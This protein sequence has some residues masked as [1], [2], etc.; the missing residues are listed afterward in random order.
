MKTRFVILTERRVLQHLLLEDLHGLVAPA[1]VELF[2]AA[3]QSYDGQ[4]VGADAFVGILQ[5]W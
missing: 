5:Y 3:V 2:L 1:L 4:F